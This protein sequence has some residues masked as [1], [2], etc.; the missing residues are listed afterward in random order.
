MWISSESPRTFRLKKCLGTY[1]DKYER[2]PV[3]RK[4]LGNYE[5]G[6]LHV[7]CPLICIIQHNDNLSLST[8]GNVLNRATQM[9]RFVVNQ[10]INS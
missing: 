5:R 4:L 10:F 8:E 2:I 7:L 6:L 3:L 9:F 1:S